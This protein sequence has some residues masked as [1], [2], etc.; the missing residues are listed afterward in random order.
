MMIQ[1]QVP[2]AQDAQKTVECS[3]VQLLD[4]IADVPVAVQHQ[5]PMAQEV[6]IQVFKGDR[7]V[8]MDNN[9]Q[10]K[11]HFNGI[12]PAPRGA[13][14]IEV[15]SGIDAN[16]GLNVSALSTSTCRSNPI[17]ITNE[18]GRLSQAETDHVTEE[19]GKYRDEDEVDKTKIDVKNGSEN[20]C[21]TMRST[22]IVG[23]LRQRKLFMPGTV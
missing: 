1:R 13:S 7:A 20:H 10:C 14:Q 18:N 11:L 15:T 19:V 4:K 9:L 3:Q 8:T 17:A 23:K 21:V 12:S 22:S 16:E 5:A 6:Q 2:T